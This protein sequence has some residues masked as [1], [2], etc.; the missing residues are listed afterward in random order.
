MAK[1]PSNGEQ[2]T[3]SKLQS[4]SS[5]C[6]LKRDC[7]TVA[8]DPSNGE[9]QMRSKLQSFSS[10]CPLKRDCTTGGHKF[11]SPTLSFS[12]GFQGEVFHFH[13]ACPKIAKNDPMDKPTIAPLLVLPP[14]KLGALT[15]G[16]RVMLTLLPAAVAASSI[17]VFQSLAFLAVKAVFAARA[18]ADARPLIV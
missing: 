13:R 6:P 7:T 1:D 18:S 15:I 11:S 12:I 2:Q 10:L 17:I 4:F 5:L 9:Q 14:L 3:R 16:A 8:K